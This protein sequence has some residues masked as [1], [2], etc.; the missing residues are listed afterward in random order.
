[1]ICD[2]LT[3]AERRFVKRVFVE[4]EENTNPW[5]LPFE[6]L[7]AALDNLKIKYKTDSGSFVN[8]AITRSFAF[9]IPTLAYLTGYKRLKK[10]I[11][12]IRRYRRTRFRIHFP[13]TV[14]VGR[15]RL[16]FQVQRTVRLN[17]GHQRYTSEV[18]NLGRFLGIDDVRSCNFGWHGPKGKEWPVFIDVNLLLGRKKRDLRSSRSSQKFWMVVT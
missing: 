17:H 7:L 13:Y 8:V 3:V 10:D 18:K 4:M 6:R 2:S 5:A 9:K 11:Q 16:G 1:M 12:F 15:D 14:F